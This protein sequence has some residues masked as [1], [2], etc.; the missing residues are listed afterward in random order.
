M[1]AGGTPART[2]GRTTRRRPVAAGADS[3]PRRPWLTALWVPAG[4]LALPAG[5]ALSAFGG[6]WYLP[7]LV[8]VVGGGIGL[9]TTLV[10][11]GAARVLRALTG[12]LL[13]AP[14]IAVPILSYH[15]TQD[16]VLAHRGVPHRGTVTQ[17]QVSHG[18]TTTYRCAV[19]YEDQPAGTH[20]VEC[21]EYDHA[22]EQVRVTA[23]P[24]GWVEPQ[25]TDLV[26]GSAVAR[27]FALMAEGGLLA[28]SL[29]LAL[30]GLLHHAWRTRRTAPLSG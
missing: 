19:R 18:K 17:V 22:G 13:I 3:Y 1:T 12:T 21:N 26:E 30:L 9:L 15:A 8:L 7:G 10:L 16:T 25:F 5:G 29:A 23:D 2:H 24:D 20:G 27:A 14:L 4:V 6:W 11:L 28:V